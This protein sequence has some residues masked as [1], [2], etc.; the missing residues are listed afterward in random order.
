MTQ[1]PFRVPKRF[2]LLGQTI[3]VVSDINM[4]IEKLDVVAF[5]CYRTNEIQLNP[6]MMYKNQEQN[7]H[8]FLH[9]LV[10]FILYHAQSAYKNKDSYMHQDED[11]VDLT[12][13]LLHQAL[14]TMEYE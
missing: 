12:A 8:A 6:A 14:T 4:F 5:A 1:V 11:F 7:E 9:E 3:T 13:N 10:H 2:K